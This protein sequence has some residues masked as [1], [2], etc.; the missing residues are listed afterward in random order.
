[1]DLD[2]SKIKRGVRDIEAKKLSDSNRCRMTIVTSGD[3]VDR[4]LLVVKNV[5]ENSGTFI[6]GTKMQRTKFYRTIKKYFPI[7]CNSDRMPMSELK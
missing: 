6:S 5:I 2:E 7:K 1:M 4:I 3:T